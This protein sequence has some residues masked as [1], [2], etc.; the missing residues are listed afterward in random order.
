[1]PKGKVFKKRMRMEQVARLESL[2]FPD[3]TIAEQVNLTPAGL[4][5]LKNS[6][7]YKRLRVTIAS[8]VLSQL[9][10]NIDTSFE[11]VKERITQMVPPALN[12][13][14]DAV[15]Q[16]QDPKLRLQAATQILDR[17][18]RLAEVKRIGLPTEAQ[19]GIG[20]KITD[21]DDEAA[22]ALLAVAKKEMNTIYGS[23]PSSSASIATNFTEGTGS[24]Q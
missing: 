3:V 2:G 22:N 24:V 12:A 14:F 21:K 18:G 16:V 23:S 8:G 19:G 7:D 10:A 15:T 20:C 5:T 13:L 11:M 6:I 17:D 9:D 4:A 1:M